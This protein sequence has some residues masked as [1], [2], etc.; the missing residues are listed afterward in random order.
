MTSALRSLKH[1][2][3]ADRIFWVS[4]TIASNAEFV[5]ELGIDE[6]DMYHDANNAA[7]K[8]IMDE[9]QKEADDWNAYEAELKIWK[10]LQRAL[11]KHG[12]DNLPEDL[13]EKAEKAGFLDGRG[14][15]E[16]KYGH[17]P[18][19]HA[20]IDDAMGEDIMSSGPRSKLV[21][22]CIKHRHIGEGLGVSLWVCVQSWSA[23][24]SLPRSVRENCTGAC[25]WF[26]PHEKQIDLMA[27]ELADRS[28][29]DAFKAA[30]KLGTQGDHDFLF[31][32]KP[33]KN[34][35]GFYNRGWNHPLGAEI[36]RLLASTDGEL[37]SAAC[38]N[39]RSS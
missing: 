12:V 23:H 6:K 21:N 15:P 28:G 3:F 13:Q 7:L 31:I 34:T 8:H 27:N 32:N 17:K 20:V 36:S 14:A 33:A 1:R 22:M 24:G 16:S 18:C 25:I 26:T 11:R 4:S 5:K 2:G 35:P 10:E 9:V 29:A 30:Y 39:E 19:L 37:A 38:S